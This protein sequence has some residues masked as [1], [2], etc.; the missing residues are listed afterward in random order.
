VRLIA[1]CVDDRPAAGRIVELARAEF[2]DVKLYVR[3]FDRRHSLEL[4]AKGVDFEVRET[5]ES[6]LEFG[7]AALEALGL[8]PERARD[9]RDYVRKR[10]LE[11]LGLQQ[12]EG[13]T[14]GRELMR[15]RMV[16]PEPLSTPLHES[17]AL[18]PEAQELVREDAEPGE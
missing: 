7:R 10:D 13:I 16:Q 2:P 1:V 18:N 6:A 4:L 14:A 15:A 11:R 8:A 17:T 12:V 5:F 3:A 9:V